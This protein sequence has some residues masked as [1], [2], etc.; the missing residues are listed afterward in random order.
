MGGNLHKGL[1]RVSFTASNPSDTRMNEDSLS[2]TSS[3]LGA[4]GAPQEPSVPGAKRQGAEATGDSG[5][6]SPQMPPN[7]GNNQLKK[8]IR[9]GLEILSTRIDLFA[10]EISEQV[11]HLC[12]I[13]VLLGIFFILLL[14]GLGFVSL[15]LVVMSILYWQFP[16]VDILLLLAGIYFVL[17][18][19][20]AWLLY[21]AVRDIPPLFSATLA[22]LRAD[23]QALVGGK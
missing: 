15:S 6:S 14:L 10:V 17:T 12:S 3:P 9:L 1:L 2:K 4:E 18:A 13:L 16:P 22:E 7:Q 8:I 5:T 21:R 11:A 19:I 20:I 23:C